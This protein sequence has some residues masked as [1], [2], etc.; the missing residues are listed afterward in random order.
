MELYIGQKINKLTIIKQSN[1][2]KSSSSVFKMYECKCE[3]GKIINIRA[4]ALRK[5]NQIS[6]GCIG[7]HYMTKSKE[8]IT[9]QN[10]RKRCN[11]SYTTGFENYGGR[12]IK[13]SE[14]WN[15][16]INFYNDMG[17]CPNGYSLDRIDNNKGYSKENCRW[18]SR[19]VQNKN[20]RNV[21]IIDYNGQ[22]MDLKDLSKMVGMSYNTLFFRH[23]VKNDLIEYI[24]SKK[25]ILN[26]ED[27]IFYDNLAVAAKTYS[28]K[29]DSIKHKFNQSGR[30]KSLILV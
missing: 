19:S 12:G 16:F 14:D 26:L 2:V 24:E 4:V 20:K 9:W 17:K 22:K 25:Y 15:N 8:F 5:G 21:S 10:M 18:T 11:K 6:C 7:K 30:Y 29:R 28:T 1:S 3:C 27:G 23:H 13:V